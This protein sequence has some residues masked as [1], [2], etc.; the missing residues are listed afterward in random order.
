MGPV[1]SEKRDEHG[2]VI[3]NFHRRQMYVSIPDVYGW[4]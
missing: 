4:L 2:M 3:S 1:Y